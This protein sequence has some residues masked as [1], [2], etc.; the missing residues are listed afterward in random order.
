MQKLNRDNAQGY[1]NEVGPQ[2]GSNLH[3]ELSNSRIQHFTF[4]IKMNSYNLS[5]LPDSRDPKYLNQPLDLSM[6]GVVTSHQL[7]N[8]LLINIFPQIHSTTFCRK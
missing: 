6:G 1:F 4:L 5:K 8:S 2:L 7:L 3:L